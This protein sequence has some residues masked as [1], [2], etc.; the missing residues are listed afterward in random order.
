M[1]YKGILLP[2]QKEI[3]EG[4]EKHKYS[5]ILAARQTGKS[6]IVSLWAFFRALEIPNHTILV[7]SLIHI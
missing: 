4:I 6:F 5:V 1:D 7:L 3:F 2:Y